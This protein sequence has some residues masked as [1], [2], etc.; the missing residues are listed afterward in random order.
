MWGRLILLKL[1]K[2]HL[3]MID[4]N[5]FKKAMKYIM[6]YVYTC[7]TNGTCKILKVRPNFKVAHLT[8]C[9]VVGSLVHW[10]T[11]FFEKIAVHDDY[12]YS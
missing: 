11:G 1:I 3:H 7:H 2:N 8:V 4:F 12:V 6:F 9:L 5:H 10:Q